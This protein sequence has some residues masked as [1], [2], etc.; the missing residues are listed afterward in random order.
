L[1][2]AGCQGAKVAPLTA[3]NHYRNRFEPGEV[4]VMSNTIQPG[5]VN[6]VQSLGKAQG[7]ESAGAADANAA[8]VDHTGVADTGDRVQLTDSARAIDAASRTNEASSSVDAGRVERVRQALAHGSYQVDAGRIADKLIALD[9]Q[10]SG[11]S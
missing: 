2:S 9:K 4:P 6:Q 10:I 8:G 7:K 3:D 5:A 1:K 11:K